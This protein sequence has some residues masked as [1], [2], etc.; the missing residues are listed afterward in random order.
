MAAGV[1]AP[2]R[3]GGRTAWAPP[4]ALAAAAALLASGCDR[5]APT[6]TPTTAA[7]G[8]A[9]SMPA[10]GA[11]GAAAVRAA[12]AA[13]P[14][15]EGRWT[16]GDTDSRY[17]AYF[18]ADALRYLEEDVARGAGGTDSQRYWY[19]DGALVYF[20]GVAP[21]ALPGAGPSTVPVVAEFRGAEVVRAVAREHSGEKKLDA[22]AVEALRRHAAA[23]A[24]AATDEWNARV[25]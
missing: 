24:G 11:S 15:V 12:A 3:P 5:V 2:A 20:E 7:S 25:R 21:S 6:P 22:A 1:A 19:E 8:G 13:W 16:R 23:L 18:D 14:R 4:F 9:A 10:A 17:V